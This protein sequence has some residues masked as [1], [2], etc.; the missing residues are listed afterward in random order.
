ML[1]RLGKYNIVAFVCLVFLLKARALINTALYIDDQRLGQIC[2]FLK[3][4]TFSLA[5]P[6]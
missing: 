3:S 6:L 1:Q 2:L 5:Q 4:L